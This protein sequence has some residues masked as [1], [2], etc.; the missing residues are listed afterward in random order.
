[1]QTKNTR[2]LSLGLL[3]ALAVLLACLPMTA[4]SATPAGPGG[5]ASAGPND[6]LFYLSPL[7]LVS[8]NEALRLDTDAQGIIHIHND[9]GSG[10]RHV[11]LTLRAPSSL[12]GKVVRFSSATI[13][14]DLEDRDSYITSTD[15]RMTHPDGSATDVVTSDDHHHSEDPDCYTLGLPAGSEVTITGPLFIR[16]GLDYDKAG[17]DQ[18]IDFLSAWVNLR[19]EPPGGPY[20]AFLPLVMK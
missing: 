16:L 19:G 10:M 12:S 8:T 17:D 15:I 11:Y 14:Y 1:M 6:H 9:S 3:L 13:C 5:T 4:S 7:D 2:A 18:D 20:R